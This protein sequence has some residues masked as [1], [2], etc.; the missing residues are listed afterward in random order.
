M[1]TATMPSPTT[2]AT[3]APVLGGWTNFNF[4][5]TDKAKKVFAQALKGFV[6]VGYTPLAFATQPVAG[7]NWCFLAKGVVVYPGGPEMAAL[8]YVYEPLEGAPHLT[9]IKQ[10]RPGY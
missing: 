2:T 7:T 1:T 5:L 10:I 3:T 6:G 4:T 8:L 9:E